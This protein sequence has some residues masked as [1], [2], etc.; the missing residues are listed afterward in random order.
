MLDLKN[1][2]VEKRLCG[3]LNEFNIISYNFAYNI[4]WQLF[5]NCIL[6]YAIKKIL[7][8]QWCVGAYPVP[9]KS[10]FAIKCNNIIIYL[11]QIFN[12][13]IPLYKLLKHAPHLLK[14]DKNVSTK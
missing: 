8:N 6:Y 12:V 1:S 3:T 11:C 10:A 14:I 13:Y 5:K 7:I 4:K 2:L 9:P